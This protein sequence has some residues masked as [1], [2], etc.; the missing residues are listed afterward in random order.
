MNR[1]ENASLEPKF[2]VRAKF[3]AIRQTYGEPVTTW[4]TRVR[5]AA[6]PCGFGR[7]RLELSVADKFVTG[8]WPGPV[9]DRMYSE[10]A[11]RPPEDLLAVAVAVERRTLGRRDSHRGGKNAMLLTEVRE[12]LKLYRFQGERYAAVRD[13]DDD[14]GGDRV[15]IIIIVL[16]FLYR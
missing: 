1:N 6:V 13:L 4:Y 16:R 15:R 3:Y 8:L 12:T 9:A 2:C 7:R 14:G 10:S 5:E 11:D